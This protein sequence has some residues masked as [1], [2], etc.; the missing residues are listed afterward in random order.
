MGYAELGF[1]VRHLD[2]CSFS[3]PLI[4]FVLFLGMEMVH[5]LPRWLDMIME[6]DIDGELLVMVVEAMAAEA[7]EVVEA[8]VVVEASVAVAMVV[9][10]TPF[11]QALAEAIEEVPEVALEV[12][13]EVTTEGLVEE[14]SEDLGDSCKGV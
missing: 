9:V 14:A 3:L 12:S 11:G 4:F 10:P 5:V 6:V 13:Q 1:L 7:T 2:L 8:M